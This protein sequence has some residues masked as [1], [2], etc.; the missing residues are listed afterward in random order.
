MTQAARPSLNA[1]VDDGITLSTKFNNAMG[2]LYT[3]HAG[4]AAPPSP[5]KGQ[6]WVDTSLEAA[7]TPVL[8]M[9]VYTGTVWR[10]LGTLDLTSGLYTTAGG[11]PL[12][13]GTVTG[14]ILF[15][16]GTAAAPSISFSGDTN[17]GI[18]RVAADQIGFTTA[19]V[20]RV[21]L[22]GTSFDILTANARI[23]GANAVLNLDRA[24]SAGSSIL[25]FQVGTSMRWNWTVTGAESTGNAGSSLFLGFGDDTGALVVNFLQFT[26]ATRQMG[27][28]GALI[29]SAP[30]TVRTT[31]TG[32]GEDALELMNINADVNS[33]V[34][35]NFRTGGGILRSAIR[36]ERPG[37]NN[38]DLAVWTSQTGVLVK[39]ATFRANGDLEVVGAVKA[40]GV[41]LTSS[42]TIKKQINDA[43]S[44]LAA[45]KKLRVVTFQRDPCAD[46]EDSR[47]ET[48]FLAEEVALVLP[49]AVTAKADGIHVMDLLASLTKAVQELSAEVAILRKEAGR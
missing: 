34:G 26:R 39:A 13:G 19:G 22:T 32:I 10:T 2:A 7:A 23:A 20:Q 35:L 46:E 3:S 12:T 16:S 28:N 48:G 30:L 38:G 36:G 24:G 37:N 31:A 44:Q 47:V 8:M 25:S 4:A 27:I 33:W 11:L 42:R 45:I 40:N 41:T 15:P 49:K 5:E 1:A 9:K 17:N 43:P 6:V 29:G 18:Y 21:L 14:P